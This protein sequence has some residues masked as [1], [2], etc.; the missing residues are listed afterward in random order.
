MPW[1][2][3]RARAGTRRTA[4]AATRS[5]KRRP[6]LPPHFSDV[7]LANPPTG[8]QGCPGAEKGIAVASV[9]AR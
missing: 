4:N 1:P 3:G 5:P 8:R 7:T 9:D 2:Q 6:W